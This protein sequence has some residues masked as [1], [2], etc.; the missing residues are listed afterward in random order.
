M[1][2]SSFQRRDSWPPTIIRIDADATVQEVYLDEP[3]DSIDAD[4]FSHFLTPPDD[5]ENPFD[6]DM[7]DLSA[8]IE[9]PS[10]SIEI[11]TRTVS[12]SNL[13]FILEEEAGNQEHHQSK[14]PL[15]LREIGN[16]RSHKHAQKTSIANKLGLASEIP[17]LV[18]SRGRSRARAYAR[19]TSPRGRGRGQTRSLP[20]RRRPHAWRVPSPDVWSIDEE[21]EPEEGVHA[22]PLTN[23]WTAQTCRAVPR[24][25]KHVRWA[26]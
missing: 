11:P 12:P 24:A 5:I 8:G 23:R 20:G 21:E 2:F 17:D 7:E 4:P 15:A 18:A 6:F 1:P 3:F 13:E 14:L 9:S 22:T 16:L 19:T 10:A 26:N 25:K